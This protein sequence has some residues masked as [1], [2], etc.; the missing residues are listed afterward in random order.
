MKNYLS[1]YTTFQII[2]I[3]THFISPLLV[4]L[5]FGNVFDE[6]MSFINVIASYSFLIGILIL[7]LTSGNTYQVKTGRSFKTKSGMS[8]NEYKDNYVPG[9]PMSAIHFYI[10]LIHILWPIIWAVYN[11]IKAGI[12]G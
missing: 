1:N 5:L 12:N 11:I 3:I 2:L 7:F 9:L 8:L 4:F 6:G 10:V